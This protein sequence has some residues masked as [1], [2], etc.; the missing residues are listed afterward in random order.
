[1]GSKEKGRMQYKSLFSLVI[2]MNAETLIII[3]SRGFQNLLYKVLRGA[4]ISLGVGV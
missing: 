3:R 2:F 4:N 1:M